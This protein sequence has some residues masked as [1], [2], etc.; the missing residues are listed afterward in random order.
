VVAPC[1]DDQNDRRFITRASP[2]ALYRFYGYFNGSPLYSMT[3]DGVTLISSGFL[4]KSVLP[5]L[6]SIGL[7]FASAAPLFSVILF[8]QPLQH[9]SMTALA[10]LPVFACYLQAEL[11]M[12][13]AKHR[14]SLISSR[15][16]INSGKQEIRGRRAGI[17]RNGG[18]SMERDTGL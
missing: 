7:P 12:T 9:D 14:C 15:F 6:W 10:A 1:R 18:Q 5:R 16:L 17:W 13:A 3:A 8:G 11:C 4:I 2:S